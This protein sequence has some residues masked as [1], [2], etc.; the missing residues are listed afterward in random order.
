MP[1]TV[2]TTTRKCLADMEPQELRRWLVERRKRLANHKQFV[3]RYFHRRGRRA[4]CGKRRTSTE[5]QYSR[6]QALTDDL[7]ELVDSVI[8]NID[9]YAQDQRY[10]Q[11]LETE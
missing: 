1:S 9:R 10:I 6:F 5:R 4:H 7:L 3:Q 2:N 11:E 8:T